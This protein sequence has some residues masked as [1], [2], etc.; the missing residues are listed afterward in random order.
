MSQHSGQR[1]DA[2]ERL[3]YQHCDIESNV[4]T[5][6]KGVISTSRRCREVYFQCRDVAEKYVFN[7]ATLESNVTTCLRGIFSIVAMFSPASRRSRDQHPGNFY[8][9][10]SKYRKTPCIQVYSSQS[11]HKACHAIS[12]SPWQPRNLETCNTNA[13]KLKQAKL[14]LANLKQEK[15]MTKII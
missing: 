13:S 12:P 7:A 3:D 2:T 14:N 8:K 5:F 4:A 1:H 9:F 10:F 15:L 11:V 6:P